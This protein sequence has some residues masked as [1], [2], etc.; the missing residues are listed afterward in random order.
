M[1]RMKPAINQARGRSMDAAEIVILDDYPTLGPLPPHQ[2]S[3]P[4]TD[5]GFFPQAARFR[6]ASP[7][8]DSRAADDDG[9]YGEG[10]FVPDGL[11]PF[12]KL[13]IMAAYDGYVAGQR[14]SGDTGIRDPLPP[15]PPPS[16]GG[17]E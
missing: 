2:A 1:T 5:R 14:Y 15:E 7:P 6:A 17:R 10:R 3:K 8:G 9:G 12:P 4:G 13:S 11:A 16:P